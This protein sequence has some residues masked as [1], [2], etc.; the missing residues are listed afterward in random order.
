MHVRDVILPLDNILRPCLLYYGEGYH[1]ISLETHSAFTL[2]WS[3]LEKAKRRQ[4]DKL[5]RK[6]KHVDFK[7]GDN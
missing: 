1:E 4:A 7:V 3:N 5:D 2:V 6:T